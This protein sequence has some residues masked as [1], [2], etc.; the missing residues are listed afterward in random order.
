M[1]PVVSSAESNGS[2]KNEMPAHSFKP[3][4]QLLRLYYWDHIQNALAIIP[5]P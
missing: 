5:H 2:E 4:S 3:L 1:N